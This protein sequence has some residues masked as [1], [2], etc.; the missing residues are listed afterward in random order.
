MF[1]FFDD[2][3]TTVSNMAFETFVVSVL[4]DYLKDQ[5]KLIQTCANTEYFDAILPDGIDEFPGPV[6]LEIKNTFSNKS[7]YF[8]SVESFAAKIKDVEKGALLLILGDVF[9]E[10]SKESMVRLAQSRAKRQVIVWDINDFNDKTKDYQLNYKDYTERPT[11]TI[12]E[13]LINSPA[14]EEELEYTKKS[15]IETLKK[16][17]KSE[18]VALFLGAGV[19]AD[20]GVPRWNELINSLL[21]EMIL[22]RAKGEPDALLSAHLNEIINIAYNNKEDSPITQMRYIRGAFNA[23]EYYQLVHDVLYNNHPKTN[24][25]LLNAIAEICTPRRNHIGVQGIVTYNFDDLLERRLERQKVATNIISNEDD[26]TDSEKLSVFH[27]HGFLPKKINEVE[28]NIELIFSEEDYHRVYRDA[29]CW[30]NLAQLNYLR[31][32]TCLF[33]GCSLTDPNL[34]RLLDVAT[35]SNEKPRHYAFLRRNHHFDT[36]GIN[37]EALN[38][39]KSIDTNLREKYYA[40]MG[41]N[42]IWIDSFEEIPQIL[43]S[44]II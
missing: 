21:S 4:R 40:T 38:I 9:T 26:I 41:L 31:E 18:E 22:R 36:N 30:S 1:F 6:Y 39:Y 23:D 12:V 43:K 37:I 17:Y 34:R 14:S 28:S 2:Q 16:K 32:R 33:I 11:K 5:G 29:Y 44:F 15:L 10:A 3:N 24:T 7:G 20:A 27:V 19:S 35:R 8:R 42:I 25:E 13:E